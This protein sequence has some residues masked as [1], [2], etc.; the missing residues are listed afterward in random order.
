MREATRSFRPLSFHERL[1]RA[2]LLGGVRPRHVAGQA[3]S[4]GGDQ[5]LG[6]DIAVPVAGVG[7]RTS[8]KWR[9]RIALR[10][11]GLSGA[12]TKFGP[13]QTFQELLPRCRGTKESR[14]RLDH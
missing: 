14:S 6:A 10:T 4:G 13:I 2:H 8:S 9:G 12:T 7:Q 11:F 5:L 3:I 1:L